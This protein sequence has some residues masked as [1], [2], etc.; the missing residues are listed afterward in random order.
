MLVRCNAIAINA[1]RTLTVA[2]FYIAQ[3]LVVCS[4]LFNDVDHV[5]NDRRFTN[6]VGHR[7][8]RNAFAR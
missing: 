4:V 7:F 2:F 5:F 8:R 6:S 1:E 3:H